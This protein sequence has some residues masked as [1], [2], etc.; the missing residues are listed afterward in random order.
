MSAEPAM[1]MDGIQVRYSLRRGGGIEHCVSKF[2]QLAELCSDTLLDIFLEQ[3]KIDLRKALKE[4]QRQ[5][6]SAA[7]L[8]ENRE[9]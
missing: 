8:S 4:H 1:F 9:Y 7:P 2:V 6:A 5:C 3:M